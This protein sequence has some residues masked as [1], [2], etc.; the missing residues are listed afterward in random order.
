[1][2]CY[3]K[4][5]RTVSQDNYKRL[6]KKFKINSNLLITEINIDYKDLLSMRKIS[7]ISHNLRPTQFAELYRTSPAKS[8]G[9]RRV[10]RGRCGILGVFSGLFLEA[11]L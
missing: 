2:I 11:L 7:V 1:M 9:F 3:Y 6:L 5:K 8:F 10:I 4:R